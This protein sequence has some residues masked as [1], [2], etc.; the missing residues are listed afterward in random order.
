MFTK[1]SY[2]PRYRGWR[3]VRGIV[4]LIDAIGSLV[5]APFGYDCNIYTDFAYR[6][7]KK[8]VARRRA[9]REDRNKVR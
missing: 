8:D 1:S 2:K 7:L 5:A 6:N 4:Q 3:F 9:K